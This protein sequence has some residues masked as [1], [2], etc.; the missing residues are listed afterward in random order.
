MLIRT[1]FNCKYH[2]IKGEEE[3]QTSYCSRENCW[4]EYSKCVANKA[5]DRFLEQETSESYRP[6]LAI[7]Q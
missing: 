7:T 4:S 3:N 2:E 5:L 1:C 6:Y